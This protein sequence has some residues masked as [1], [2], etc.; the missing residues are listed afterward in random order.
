MG[1]SL[2]LILIGTVFAASA[3]AELQLTPSILE[4]EVDGAKIKLLAFPDGDRK[5]TYQSPRGWDYSGSPTQLTLRPINKSQAEAT[6]TKIALSEPG[7][8]DAE[9]LKKVVAEMTAAL[10]KGSENVSLISQESNPLRIGGKETVLIVLSYRFFGQPYNRSLLL[11][12]RGNEQIRFQLV[13]REGD[14]KELQK[15]FLA[16]QYTWHDL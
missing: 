15:A 12:N 13:S 3:R 4:N 1:S 8:F 7:K 10:P 14:F 16:S 2:K 11:L 5:V 6:I 9:T